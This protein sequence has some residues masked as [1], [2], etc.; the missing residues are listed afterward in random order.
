M[1]NQSANYTKALEC[2]VEFLETKK[3]K[4]LGGY[5]NTP[6][7]TCEL[8]TDK[9]SFLESVVVDA[10][11][12]C[13]EIKVYWCMDVVPEYREKIN[14]CLKRINDILSPLSIVEVDSSGKVYS[15]A[16]ENYSMHEITIATLECIEELCLEAY[17]NFASEVVSVNKGNC[18]DD[19]FFDSFVSA[20]YFSGEFRSG[21]EYDEIEDDNAEMITFDRYRKIS[22][23]P[24]A[25][26]GTKVA[27]VVEIRNEKLY[28]ADM[29]VSSALGCKN[30]NTCYVKSKC[31]F[32]DEKYEYIDLYMTGEVLDNFIIRFGTDNINEK[33][34]VEA[35]VAYATYS[36]SGDPYYNDSEVEDSYK[37]I[38]II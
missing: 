34:V 27:F 22:L 23:R 29:H 8:K 35:E 28:K 11:E 14:E 38:N 3:R 20:D 18:I 5:L 31:V 36:S 21:Y 26:K 25:Y 15:S 24:A 7:Y 33:I 9:G 12:E 37:V 19:D 4:N 1:K 2:I 30:G 13:V 6:G 32:E 17:E 16:K 10:Q